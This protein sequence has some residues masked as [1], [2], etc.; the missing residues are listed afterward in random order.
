MHF[1]QSV[2]TPKLRM[3]DQTTAA[4]L[5]KVDEAAGEA[6]AE[7]EREE[8]V[9]RG[10]VADW[11]AGKLPMPVALEAAAVGRVGIAVGGF[12]PHPVGGASGLVHELGGGE[13]AVAPGDHLG[14][15]AAWLVSEWPCR[16]PGAG[17]APPGGA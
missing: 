5:A 11:I 2:P 8:S 9:A 14:D 4:A 7:Y 12:V 17:E 6:A 1:T 15:R 10:T 3:L 16:V 13:V